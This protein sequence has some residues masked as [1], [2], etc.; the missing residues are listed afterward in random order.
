MSLASQFAIFSTN[1]SVEN[2]PA[3]VIEKARACVLNG[4]GIALGSYPTPFFGVAESA[5]LAMDGERPGGATLL[6]SGRRSTVAGAA[7]ANAALFHGR[8]QEDT[9]GVA[10]F[11]AILLP[12]LTA[13]VEQGE[14][15][16]ADFLPALVAGY[17]VGGALESA[18]SARTTAAGLRA[19]PLYGTIAAAAAVARLW[20]LPA[21]RTAAALSNAASFSGGILQSFG[22]GTDEWRY[23]VGM[24]GRNGLAAA[25]L[26]ARGSVS[27]DGA[28]EG[29]SGFVRA[30]VREE[31][32]AA[33]IAGRLGQDW[34]LLK[35]TFKPYPVCALNQ[36]PVRACLQLRDQLGARAQAV[37]TLRV[38]LNPTVVG[39]AGMD[40]EGP[41]QSIS[42]T[43][44][45]TQFCVATTLLHGTPTI[46]RMAQFDDAAVAGLIPRIRLHADGSLGLLA[47]RIEAELEGEDEPV[48]VRMDTD[49]TE[50]S[51][52]RARVSALIRGIG[53]ETGVAPRAYDRIERFAA[54][55]PDA[56]LGDVLAAFK[57]IQ[58]A[59]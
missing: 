47:C 58:T 46:A 20:R 16:M 6:G 34:S 50:Y 36:T 52:D 18:Y 8:A 15:A 44:M 29:R 31:C 22:D 41:F 21:D 1:L 42:G 14:G 59:R 12:L 5:V 30:F 10:H 13:L 23:Q 11:G 28:F 17:E 25:T 53:E 26:A 33:A 43:L 4:Y 57:E 32:D 24:A 49:H 45:S 56:D 9:C 38:H 39:Y 40:K 35:V 19:S 27:A 54:A 2:L 55:L 37:K 48:V 51:Y 3:P 7:L